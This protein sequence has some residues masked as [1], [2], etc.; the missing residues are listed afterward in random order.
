M[1]HERCLY[2]TDAWYMPGCHQNQC[3]YGA[4]PKFLRIARETGN[5]SL[6]QTVRRMTGNAAL[7]FDLEN[8]GFIREG[9]FADITVFNPQTVRETSTPKK[10]DSDPVGI[11]YVIVNGH[12]LLAKG[13]LHAETACG[14]VI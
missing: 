7:R 13:E 4:M 9:Y 1:T 3:A 14:R 12:T 8:R 10:P 11:E 2:M 6:E 5:Q